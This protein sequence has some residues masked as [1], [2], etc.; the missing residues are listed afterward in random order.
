M[1][2]LFFSAIIF[3][4]N[5]STSEHQGSSPS[6][7][8]KQDG[9]L[10]TCYMCNMT[11]NYSYFGR[12]PR[13]LKCLVFLEECYLNR[14]P[15]SSPGSGDKFLVLGGE[16]VGCGRCVCQALTCSV[17]YTKR[18]CVLCAKA[19]EAEFPPEV[20]AKLPT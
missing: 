14:N 1:F 20:T 9:G 19:N 7:K 2:Y 18:F 4:E 6:D 11:E 12:S 16:C 10:F 5:M 8:T 13:F 3:P 15:F 17:F